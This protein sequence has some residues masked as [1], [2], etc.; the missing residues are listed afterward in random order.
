MT[1]FWTVEIQHGRRPWT[2]FDNGTVMATND[3]D[4]LALGTGLGY[5]DC[6]DNHSQ[7]DKLVGS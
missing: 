6:R 3:T 5:F 7:I 2:C 1:T 4:F